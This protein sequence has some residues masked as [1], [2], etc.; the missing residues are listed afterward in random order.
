MIRRPPR[1]TRTDTLFPYTTLFRS[2]RLP[3]HIYP[4]SEP[5]DPLGKAYPARQILQRAAFQ[6]P[7]GALMPAKQSATGNAM[8]RLD[9]IAAMEPEMRM[10]LAQVGRYAITG[11]AVTALQ[12]PAYWVLA[13][14]EERS[15]GEECVSQCRSRGGQ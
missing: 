9:E 13:R 8:K 1:S 3:V 11:L 4:G 2:Q 10:L 6:H 14:S 15:V 7:L 12:A 5:V